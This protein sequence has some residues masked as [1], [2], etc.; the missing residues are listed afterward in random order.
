MCVV[1]AFV[2]CTKALQVGAKK[3]KKSGHDEQAMDTRGQD[4]AKVTATGLQ[5]VKGRGD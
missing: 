4:Q 3:E 5:D 2:E 1:G